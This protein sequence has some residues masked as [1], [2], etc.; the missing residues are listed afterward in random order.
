MST[1]TGIEWTQATWNPVTGCTRASAGCDNCYAVK[2]SYRLERMGQTEKYGGLTVLNN[3]G[4]RHFNGVVRC[5]EDALDIP[6]HWSKPRRIF[7]N[8]MSDLFHKGVPV[9]FI[10]KVYA[11]MWR[12]AP[13]SWGRH[14]EMSPCHVFQILTKRPERAA[15]ILNDPAFWELVVRFSGCDSRAVQPYP[16]IWLG[17]SCED[18]PH[19]DERTMHLRR[20]PAAVRFVSA[21]PLLGPIDTTLSSGPAEG[22][23][24]VI[25]GG[26]SGPGAR[27]LHL[28]W[29]RSI[30][31]Q[32][33]E[34][35]RACFVK[36]LGSNAWSA[37]KTDHIGRQRAG[38]VLPTA[39][40]SAEAYRLWLEN[41]KGGDPA[42]W[43]ADLNVREF[44]NPA[45]ERTAST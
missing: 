16:H 35:G 2:Q 10:A 42:E 27:E 31:R 8:S 43:P 40:V 25:V 5:H 39:D 3:R 34:F 33:A 4:E 28:P 22:I 14:L 44:P 24:W 30:I 45:S 6:L 19:W 9:E 29:V 1:G 12:C 21:E 15:V 36:Q 20:C 37:Q 18:Q 11:T 17:V 41:K 26:E 38:S 7:V 13:S 23:D 32:S